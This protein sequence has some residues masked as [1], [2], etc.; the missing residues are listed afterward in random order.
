[1]RRPMVDNKGRAVSWT[2]S[3]VC[4]FVTNTMGV[5][6]DLVLLMRGS[7]SHVHANVKV[8]FILRR[9]LSESSTSMS[10]SRNPRSWARVVV[11]RERSRTALSQ[12]RAATSFILK[13]T[14]QSSPQRARRTSKVWEDFSERGCVKSVPFLH[15]HALHYCKIHIVDCR[16]NAVDVNS[17]LRIY[18]GKYLP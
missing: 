15:W 8:Y 14:T 4:L 18:C 13:P 3:E 9:T 12:T 10:S 11:W 5:C 6:T 16:E 17:K 1:M 7:R 2:F